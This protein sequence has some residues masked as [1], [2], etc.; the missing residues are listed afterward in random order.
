[1]NILDKLYD[2]EIFPAENAVPN[3]EEYQEKMRQKNFL[4]DKLRK[5]MPS[6][7]IPLLEKL[8]SLYMSISEE[9]CRYMYAEGVRFGIKLM[10]DV[11]YMDE[12]RPFI[13]PQDK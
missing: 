4:I 7:I 6:D 5:T 11:S 8:S 10:M 13:F 12:K 1:M 3:T 9:E 2:G